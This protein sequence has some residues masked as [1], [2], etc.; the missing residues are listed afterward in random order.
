MYTPGHCYFVLRVYSTFPFN[1]MQVLTSQNQQKLI[2][3]T[4]PGPC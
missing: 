2:Q 3:R 4:R 1:S